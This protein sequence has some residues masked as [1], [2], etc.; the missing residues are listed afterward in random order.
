MDDDFNTP[1]AI[2]ALNLLATALAEEHK[3]VQSGARSGHDFVAGVERPDPISGKVLGLSMTGN[4]SARAQVFEP[5]RRAHIDD[6]VQE[7]GRGPA[8][9]ATG[10][11]RMPCG[12][13]WT[14]SA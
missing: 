10:R 5:E 11:G 14:R 9:S 8:A 3:R 7:A 1:Q 12:R 6:L 4:E 2:G 13:S